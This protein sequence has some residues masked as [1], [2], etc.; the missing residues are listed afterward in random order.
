MR[1]SESPEAST[2]SVL[3]LLPLRPGNE[4]LLIFFSKVD[5]AKVE[6]GQAW[7]TTLH[8]MVLPQKEESE[9]LIPLRKASQS[10]F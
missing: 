8:V 4:P 1:G 10:C 3:C 7:F 5:L 6:W 9:G 2:R